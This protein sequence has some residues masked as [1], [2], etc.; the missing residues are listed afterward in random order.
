MQKNHSVYTIDW[1][2]DI[3]VGITQ[4]TSQRFAQHLSNSHNSG[5][6]K[7]VSAGAVPIVIASNLSHEEALAIESELIRTM[8]STSKTVHNIVG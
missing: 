1:D 2:E 5:V 3:Y 6:R 8:R 4:N 7:I